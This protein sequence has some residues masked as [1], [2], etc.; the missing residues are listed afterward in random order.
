MG[1]L[2][3]ILESQRQAKSIKCKCWE[4]GLTSRNDLVQQVTPAFRK[5]AFEWLPKHPAPHPPDIDQQS[6]QIDE[7]DHV[8]TQISARFNCP[9]AS[10]CGG[11]SVR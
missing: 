10:Y 9:D 7:L 4:L 1:Y 5:V 2:V 11:K 8:P 3:K 6:V